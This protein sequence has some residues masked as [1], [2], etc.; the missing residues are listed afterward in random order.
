MEFSFSF[1]IVN[2]GIS[3]TLKTG[4]LW[5]NSISTEY[6]ESNVGNRS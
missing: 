4:Y 2:Q 5:L 1:I 6:K 3:L